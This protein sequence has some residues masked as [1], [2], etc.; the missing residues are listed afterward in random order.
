MVHGPSLAPDCLLNYPEN[1]LN[2]TPG[3]PI[4]HPVAHPAAA[5]LP[6]RTD[7]GACI[8]NGVEIQERG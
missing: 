3:S 2:S 6:G 7:S 1:R 4:T 8:R 5:R